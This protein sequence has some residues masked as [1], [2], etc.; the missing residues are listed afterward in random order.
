MNYQSVKEIRILPNSKEV[1]FNEKDFKY[2]I[3]H[4]L[5]KRTNNGR[6]IYYVS[7]RMMRCS[8]NTL[9]LFQYDNMIRAV[10]ILVSEKKEHGYSESGEEYSG[11]YLFDIDSICYLKKPINGESIKKIHSS[12][13]NFNQSFQIIPI[14]CLN[15][16]LSL[17]K[18]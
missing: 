9:V 11:Y 5:D 15:E 17:L 4:S 8:N 10:G 3:T 6:T 16:I 12:F 14:D 7:N 1:F 13:K 2:Y 18:Q